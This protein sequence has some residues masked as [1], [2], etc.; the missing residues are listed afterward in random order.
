M[1]APCTAISDTLYPTSTPN[2]YGMITKYQLIKRR[3]SVTVDTK[4]A[5]LHARTRACRTVTT[6]AGEWYLSDDGGTLPSR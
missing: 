1:L 2:T 5:E 4:N 6:R 3:L